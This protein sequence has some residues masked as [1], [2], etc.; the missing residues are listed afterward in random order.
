MLSLLLLFLTGP[1]TSGENECQ[2]EKN[3]EV[4]VS[5]QS[6][7][8][9]STKK[10]Y[11]LAPYCGVYAVCLAA[12]GLGHDVDFAQMVSPQY[13]GSKAGS[14]LTELQQLCDALGLKTYFFSKLAVPSLTIAKNPLI[15]H[16]TFQSGNGKYEH[17]TLFTGIE[18][19]EAVTWNVRDGEAVAERLSLRDLAA[20][21]DGAALTISNDSASL[22]YFILT[23]WLERILLCFLFVVLVLLLFYLKKSV[24]IKIKGN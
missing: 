8:Q 16:T 20:K 23:V 22:N 19:G 4:F 5:D 2:Q 13:I 14:S 12:R 1:L 7:S 21:W 15:L 3:E 10:A 24:L 9:R 11:S 6:E 17:W 18:N